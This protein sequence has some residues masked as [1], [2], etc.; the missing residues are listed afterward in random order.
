MPASALAH[1]VRCLSGQARAHLSQ[2]PVLSA[3][4]SCLAVAPLLNLDVSSHSAG[5]CNCRASRDRR[6]ALRILVECVSRIRTDVLLRHSCGT[7]Y[8][9]VMGEGKLL[10]SPQPE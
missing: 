1:R 2:P 6:S 3:A 4:A 10:L 5:T 9:G 8:V 7:N